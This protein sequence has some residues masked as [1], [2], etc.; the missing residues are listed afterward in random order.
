MAEQRVLRVGVVGCG[1]F[2]RNHAR[3]YRDLSADPVRAVQFVGVV[4]A[5]GARARAIAKE[6]SATAF[7]RLDDLIAAGVDA[8][9]VAV[10]TVA[11]LKVARTLLERGVDVLIE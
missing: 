10:P 11:H 1:A 6:F 5:D 2:G 3:V 9:S 8:V 4:D 7:E